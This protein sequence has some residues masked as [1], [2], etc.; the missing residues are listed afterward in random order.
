MTNVEARKCDKAP[1]WRFARALDKALIQVAPKDFRMEWRGAGIDAPFRISC[2]IGTTHEA[3]A[4]CEIIMTMARGT[5]SARRPMVKG[6][7]YPYEPKPSFKAELAAMFGE[8]ITRDSDR[9]PEGGDSATGSI[10][11]ESAGRRHR[12]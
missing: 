2:T 10:E 11:D 3:E 4:V 12:P 1:I 9:S 8:T 5:L 6:D 7:I